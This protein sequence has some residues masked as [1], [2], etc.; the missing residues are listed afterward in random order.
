MKSSVD[1]IR[2]RFDNEVDRFANLDTGQSATMDAP[3]VLDLITHAAAATTPRAASV[4]DIGCGAGNYT[5]KL[6]QRLPNLNVTLLD[7]SQ[8]MLDRAAGRVRSVTTG[9]VITRQQDIR[10]ADLKD[11]QFDI[12]LAAAVLHHLRTDDE[13]QAVFTKLYRALAPGGSIWISDLIE[14]TTAPIQSMMYQRYGDYLSRLKDDAYRQK[15]F[16]Y[17]EQEDTP[18]PLMFQIDLLRSVGFL[19][20]DI[21]HKNGVFAAFGGRKPI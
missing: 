8:P 6:L 18:R 20:V 15:V 16:E 7:L 10:Q 14:H 13:W 17:I 4:L 9:T 3:L 11:G 5:L 21:L 2:T 19:D 12:I 1:Q